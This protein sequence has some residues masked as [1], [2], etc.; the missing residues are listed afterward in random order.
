MKVKANG[1]SFNFEISGPDS[2]A[3]CPGAVCV[4]F[5]QA[6]T[7]VFAESLNKLSSLSVLARLR[8]RSDTF[9]HKG[10]R[11]ESTM[12]RRNNKPNSR[13]RLRRRLVL[14]LAHDAGQDS[15]DLLPGRR[16]F[17][18]PG[19]A[20]PL[21]Q[22]PKQRDDDCV[23]MGV[24]SQAGSH[25]GVRPRFSTVFDGAPLLSRLETTDARGFC[26]RSCNAAGAM[27]VSP[28]GRTRSITINRE[29]ILRLVRRD[30]A[31]PATKS[32]E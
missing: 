11:K 13:R 4:N 7:V 24:L 31:R 26:S 27:S 14:S 30:A 9:S 6:R 3:R 5:S 22:G 12:H 19:V 2:A 17:R 15:I 8:L 18:S 23:V 32:S 29:N 16:S 21:L 20:E 1:I 28:A 10:R 25:H